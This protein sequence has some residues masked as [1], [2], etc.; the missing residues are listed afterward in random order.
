MRALQVN[1]VIVLGNRTW[2]VQTIALGGLSTESVIGL[3]VLDLGDA[4]AGRTGLP[5]LFVPEIMIRTM[6][7]VGILRVE[8]GS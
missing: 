5:E 1:D 6:Q 8:S 2:S 4:Y 3:Q 7:G